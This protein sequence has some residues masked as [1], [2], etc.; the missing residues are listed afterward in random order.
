MSSLF[1]ALIAEAALLGLAVI[2]WIAALDRNDALTRARR[3]APV[4]VAPVLPVA[5]CKPAAYR[6]R[7]RS[8]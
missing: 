1:Y 8:N 5:I 6:R 7:D 2:A 3:A 4:M